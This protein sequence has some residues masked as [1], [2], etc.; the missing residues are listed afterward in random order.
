MKNRILMAILPVIA[1]F[2][3][4]PERK[5]GT[6]AGG[7]FPNFT[8]A[9][10]CDSLFSLTTGAGNTGV[11]WRA[12]FFDYY[13]QLQYRCRRWSADPKYTRIPIRQSA[14]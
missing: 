6:G 5:H 7:C 12:L 1:C 8:T 4:L 14:R 9:A 11:G 3:L 2:A 13:R 10:G